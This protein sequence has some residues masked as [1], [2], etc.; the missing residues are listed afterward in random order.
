MHGGQTYIICVENI[1]GTS[2]IKTEFD[3]ILAKHQL[4]T[5]Y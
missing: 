5:F 2:N 1:I 3:K 4:Y